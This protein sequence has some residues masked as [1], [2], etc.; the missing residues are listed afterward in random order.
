MIAINRKLCIYRML[1]M[2]K[3][4]AY[5]FM[6]PRKLQIHLTTIVS[7]LY[8][9]FYVGKGT[10]DRCDPE[11]R[12][13]DEN[14]FFRER[15]LELKLLG[16]LPIVLVI[17]C[18]TEEEAFTIE[19]QLSQCL[20]IYPTG[21]MCNLRFGGLGGFTLSEYTKKLLSDLNSG[22]KNPN[23]GKPWSQE[24]RSKHKATWD[25]KREAGL[26]KK[27]HEEMSHTWAGMRRRY[28]IVSSDGTI[29]ETGDLTNFCKDH[30]F[31]LS[32][33]RTALKSPNNT[34]TSKFGKK[35]LS[36]IEGYRIYYV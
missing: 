12:L 20:G 5:I 33:I 19:F 8:A 23:F 34:V 9:P 22:E 13:E 31:P 30:D 26:T 32:A 28:K 36:K 10:G 2:K 14:P 3:P 24:R 11:T 16:L 15:L 18:N 35:R 1:K 6:D 7:I 25:K 29:Y 27:S 21:D 4:Y 17:E